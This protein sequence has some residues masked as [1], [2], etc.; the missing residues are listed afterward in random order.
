VTA[1]HD[2]LATTAGV[3]VD[4][5]AG[6]IAANTVAKLLFSSGSTGFPKGVITTNGM[7]TS[8]VHTLVA[9]YE[10]PTDEPPV[11]ADW[12]PWSHVFGGTC[13]FGLAVFR[14]GTLFIDNGLPLPSQIERTVR[15]LREIAPAFYSSV[16]RGY[17]ALVPW[18]QDDRELRQRFFRAYGC[19]S[20]RA[21]RCLSMFATRL[22]SRR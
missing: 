12:L 1:F 16:P 13:S 18:L 21:R 20:T 6:A 11:L 10:L 19:L 14:G 4:A 2:L 3:A 22:T 15:N 5:A 17:E 8:C 7:V 9:S